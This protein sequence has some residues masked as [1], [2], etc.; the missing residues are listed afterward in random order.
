MSILVK[1]TKALGLLEEK[2]Q[3]AFNEKTHPCALHP[4]KYVFHEEKESRSLVVVFSAFPAANSTARYNY[5]RSLKDV[6]TNKL[7]IL[8]DFGFDQRGS[9]YLGRDGNFQ[10]QDATI[11]LINKIRAENKIEKMVFAGSSKGGYASIFFS[12][13]YENTHI[14]AGGP[15]YLLGE[16]LNTPDHAHIL[17]FI[18][19]DSSIESVNS[20]N[21]LS[22]KILEKKISAT[23]TYDIFCSKTDSMYPLHVK[24]LLD[25]LERNKLN[26]MFN[27]GTYATHDDLAVEFPAFLKTTVQNILY[28]KK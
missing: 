11:S 5:M 9:Y 16:Y 21:S 23:C 6:N 15:Q 12:S 26:F 28:P 8:D 25:D 7:F 1:M 3:K 27:L 14:I 17:K 19:G 22:R 13:F 10:I 18:C 2:K 24:E 4:M 20:L